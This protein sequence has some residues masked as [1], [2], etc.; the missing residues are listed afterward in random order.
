MKLRQA[1]IAA[2]LGIAVAVPALAGHDFGDLFQRNINQQSRLEKALRS[3]ELTTEEAAALQRDQARI[4]RLQAE[5]LDDGV[6]SDAERERIRRLQ[7]RAS[8]DIYYERHNRE[9]GDPGSA[10][11]QRMLAS[12]ERNLRQ[13]L[14]IQRGIDSGQ[15]GAREIADLLHGQAR[16]NWRQARFAGDGWVD[17]E[18]HARIDHA[19]DRQS[20]RIWERKHDQSTRW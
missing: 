7:D 6:L 10:S 18:E 14:R 19:Q 1:L 3:G 12:V 9:T 17:A 5:A 4:A 20:E 13:Q 16:L 8:E 15:L 2:A 11:A